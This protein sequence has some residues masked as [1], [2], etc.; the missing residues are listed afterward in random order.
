MTRCSRP[1]IHVRMRLRPRVRRL[2]DDLAVAHHGGVRA[3]TGW[4]EAR[5]SHLLHRHHRLAAGDAQRI[6]S[7]ASSARRLVDVGSRLGPRQQHELETTP[8]FQQFAPRGL[9]EASRCG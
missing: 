7:A 1:A 5:V 4:R 6:R 3:S 8:S 2:A 9:R